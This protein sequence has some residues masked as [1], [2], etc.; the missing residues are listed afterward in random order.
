MSATKVLRVVD[1]P[2]AASVASLTRRSDASIVLACLSVGPRLRMAALGRGVA[3]WV[4]KLTPAAIEAAGALR[5][6]VYE[7]AAG[8]FPNQFAEVELLDDPLDD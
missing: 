5:P 4:D 6:E 1:S 8:P 2:S 3:G 7:G